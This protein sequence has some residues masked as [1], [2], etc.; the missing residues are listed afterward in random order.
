MPYANA[1]V[2]AYLRT[3]A[4]LQALIDDILVGTP[5]PGSDEEKIATLYR[6][7]VDVA[8]RN[9]LGLAPL[10]SDLDAIAAIASHGDAARHHGAPVHEVADRRRCVHRRRRPQRYVVMAGQSGSDCRAANIYLLGGGTLRGTPRGLC[11]LHR[12]RLQT[13]GHRRRS[14]RAKAIVALE[15]EIAAAHWSPAEMRDPVRSYRLLGMDALQAYAPG[16]AWTDT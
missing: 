2:D 10:Q 7:Y 13:R 15:T 1:F 6:S 3:Q 14:A 9:A 5:V 12:G 16:F 8:K 4:Q 11:S